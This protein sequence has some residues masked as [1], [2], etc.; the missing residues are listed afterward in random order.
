MYLFF[1]EEKEDAKVV[2]DFSAMSKRE[3]LQVDKSYLFVTLQLFLPFICLLQ[4]R[5]PF[6]NYN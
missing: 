1:Q 5:F 2:K 4:F 3:K 6:K